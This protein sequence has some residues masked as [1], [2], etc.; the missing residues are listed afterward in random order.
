MYG[1]LR[2]L[3]EM[4]TSVV[5]SMIDYI[6]YFF[7]KVIYSYVTYITLCN[8]KERS[9]LNKNKIIRLS[10]MSHS[11]LYLITNLEN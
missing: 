4:N 3:C 1:N 2:V 6:Y 7:F 8:F 5:P 9:I 10:C 11:S